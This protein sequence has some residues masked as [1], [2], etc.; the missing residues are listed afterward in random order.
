MSTLPQLAEDA[1]RSLLRSLMQQSADPH[2]HRKGQDQSILVSGESGAGKTVTTKIVMKYL[3]TLSQ[4]SDNHRHGGSSSNSSSI[5]AQGTH[6]FIWFFA[7]ERGV[8]HLLIIVY[9][10]SPIQPYIGIL[11]K[12]QNRTKRQFIPLWKVY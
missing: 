10:S 5:E 11:W 2:G 9:C 3:T 12:C 8:T 1:Y 4:K 7:V 6:R